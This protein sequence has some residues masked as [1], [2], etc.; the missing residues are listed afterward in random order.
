MN[1]EESTVYPGKERYW[2]DL[3]K[4]ESVGR[5]A[6]AT[7][8][9]AES[10][11]LLPSLFVEPAQ[12]QE[13]KDE[14]PRIAELRESNQELRQLVQYLSKYNGSLKSLIE[15]EYSS[16]TAKRALLEQL[17][18]EYGLSRRHVCRL[19]NLARSTC[20]YRSTA[21]SAKQSSPDMVSDELMQEGIG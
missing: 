16:P 3:P 19:L 12:T 1:S 15:L 18:K 21:K 14:S 4:I 7:Q 17:V 8:E 9:S 11:S 5:I 6:P 2:L 10:A 13:S 20:W